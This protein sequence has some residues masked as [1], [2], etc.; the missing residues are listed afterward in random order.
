MIQENI[1]QIVDKIDGLHYMYNDWANANI[2]LDTL[3]NQLPVCISILPTSGDL[4][5]HN[6]RFRDHPHCQIAFVDCCPIDWE[7][8]DV[9]D[10]I[11][12]MKTFAMRFIQGVNQS[13]K[14]VSIDKSIAYTVLYDQ[15]DQGVAGVSISVQLKELPGLCITGSNSR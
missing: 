7:A 12:R 2:A 13:D 5:L 9:E 14:F 4:H 15:L 10:I 11:C 8:N 6:G 3:Q 1:K